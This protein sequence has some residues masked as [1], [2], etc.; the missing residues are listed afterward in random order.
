VLCNS[1][2]G[3]VKGYQTISRIRQNMSITRMQKKIAHQKSKGYLK[4]D[5]MVKK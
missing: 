2:Y 5:G 3:Y 4:M 1:K